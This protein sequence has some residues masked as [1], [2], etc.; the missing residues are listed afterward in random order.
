M[1][2][3]LPHV[4]IYITQSKGLSK[5]L[6]GVILQL[7]INE[8][9]GRTKVN[10]VDEQ[11]IKLFFIYTILTYT[12]KVDFTGFFSGYYWVLHFHRCFNIALSSR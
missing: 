2:P 1:E 6:L 10:E 12:D 4:C 5:S 7:F 3:S 8:R 9:S 11:K